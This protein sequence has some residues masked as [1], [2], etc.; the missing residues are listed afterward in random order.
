MY[1]QLITSDVS[2]IKITYFYL[3]SVKN[4]SVAIITSFENKISISIITQILKYGVLVCYK[5]GSLGIEDKYFEGLLAS[6]FASKK[7][8]DESGKEC[9]IIVI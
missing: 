5:R 4:L 2:L 3:K 1:L 8:E 9:I 7:S 6:K